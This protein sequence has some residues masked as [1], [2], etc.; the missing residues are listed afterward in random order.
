YILV[1][2]SASHIQDVGARAKRRVLKYEV[3]HCLASLV[4]SVGCF[5]VAKIIVEAA[6]AEIIVRREKIVKLVHFGSFR[7]EE[8]PAHSD[9][10]LKSLAESHFPI[11][12]LS[13]RVAPI[14][15]SR[16]DRV[17]L[18]LGRHNYVVHQFLPVSISRI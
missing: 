8:E 3:N 11:R 10:F 5:P 14:S 13:K 1:A 7:F 2:K 17:R 9:T 15:L 16:L 18:F 6:F 12:D 4:V